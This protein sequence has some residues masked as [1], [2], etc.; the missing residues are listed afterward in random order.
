MPTRPDIIRIARAWTGTPYHHQASTKGVGTDCLGLILGI[1]RELYGTTPEAPPPYSPDWAEASGRETLLDA[2]R[3]HLIPIAKEI[4][5]PGDVLVFRY[6][7]TTPA[8]HLAI[9]TDDAHMLHA[10]EGRAVTEHAYTPWWSRRLAAALK[11]P[12]VEP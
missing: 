7:A 2:A 9:L 1:W 6:R 11:F 4:L 3:R 10:I 5:L 8:K 12:N